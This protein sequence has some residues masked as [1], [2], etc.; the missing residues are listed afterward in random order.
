MD[1][2][3]NRA[4]ARVDMAV[5]RLQKLH[6]DWQNLRIQLLESLETMLPSYPKSMHMFLCLVLPERDA[7]YPTVPASTLGIRRSCFQLNEQ[8]SRIVSLQQSTTRGQGIRPASLEHELSG[9][10]QAQTRHLL[11]TMWSTVETINNALVVAYSDGQP[12]KSLTVKVKDA[13]LHYE[14]MCEWLIAPRFSSSWR[15]LVTGSTMS[16]QMENF[17][18]VTRALEKTLQGSATYEWDQLDS[19]H[20]SEYLVTRLATWVQWLVEQ[21]GSGDAQTDDVVSVA[22]SSM[23]DVSASAFRASPRSPRSDC[24]SPVRSVA[25]SAFTTVSPSRPTPLASSMAS[26]STVAVGSASMLGAS[27][28]SALPSQA[29]LQSMAASVV[30]STCT[31]VVDPQLAQSVVSTAS[32]VDVTQSMAQRAAAE[33][34]PAAGNTSPQSSDESIT[35]ETG[36]SPKSDGLPPDAV[37]LSEG[38]TSPCSSGE[39][40]H[41]SEGMSSDHTPRAASREAQPAPVP[42]PAAP[43]AAALA[44]PVASA[45]P[46]PAHPAPSA[47]Q[48]NDDASAAI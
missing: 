23:V 1:E 13:I 9:K 35:V 24:S 45:E 42:V 10:V 44:G 34:R 33:A 31:M 4:R 40:E 7:V 43:A 30:S 22:A 8:W 26:D 16:T 29:G 46:L 27:C 3:V 28:E 11:T 5:Q 37:A 14:E 19:P 36:N 17:Q 25:S 18:G 47:S 48:A 20:S 32:T 15:A 12:E 39:W 2:Q 38:C 41:I 6:T 21:L